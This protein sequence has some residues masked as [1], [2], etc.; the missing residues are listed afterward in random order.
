MTITTNF[1]PTPGIKPYNYLEYYLK[2]ED[3]KGEVLLLRS[4]ETEQ[5]LE[6]AFNEI[7]DSKE[8]YPLSLSTVFPICCGRYDTL[9]Q[10]LGSLFIPQTLDVFPSLESRIEQVVVTA[11]TLIYDLITLLLRAITAIP[12]VIYNKCIHT[13]ED[14]KIIALIRDKPLAAH[15]LAE[16]RVIIRAIAE[17]FSEIQPG[18]VNGKPMYQVKG[19]IFGNTTEVRIKQLLHAGGIKSSKGAD[20]CNGLFNETIETRFHAFQ[21]PHYSIEAGPNSLVFRSF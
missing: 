9:T 21:Q 6:D 16:G 12:Y 18:S 15:A 2:I 8:G 4:Y 17:K 10:F 11:L 14:H 7:K 1:V 5:D 20:S 3:S 19:T 13:E